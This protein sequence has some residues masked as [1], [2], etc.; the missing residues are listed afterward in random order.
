MK[1]TEKEFKESLVNCEKREYIELILSDFLDLDFDLIHKKLVIDDP[2]IIED[3]TIPIKERPYATFVSIDKYIVIILKNNSREE[4]NSIEAENLLSA[5]YKKYPDK[6]IVN[7]NIN[8]Y[9]N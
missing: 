4:K 6:T 5:L 3:E 8:E 9:D 2:D 7:I 1:I